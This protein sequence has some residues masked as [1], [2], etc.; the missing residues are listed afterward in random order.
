MFKSSSELLEYALR[1]L[2]VAV[3]ENKSQVEILL[4]DSFPNDTNQVRKYCSGLKMKLITEILREKFKDYDI[5]STVESK[6]A[7]KAIFTFE[8]GP[9]EM[10]YPLI[11]ELTLRKK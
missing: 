4:Q 5:K 6:G 9:C 8:R 3:K 7:F 10:L 2:Q 11:W 1:K